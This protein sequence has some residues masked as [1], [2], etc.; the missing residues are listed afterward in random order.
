MDPMDV[1]TAPALLELPDVLLLHVLSA[2]PMRSVVAFRRLSNRARALASDNELW[3]ALM[4]REYGA[5]DGV[6][7][8]RLEG[9]AVAG[10]CIDAAREWESLCLSIG[11]DEGEHELRQR[12]APLYARAVQSWAAIGSWAEAAHPRL[13]ATLGPPASANEWRTY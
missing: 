4:R 6:P 5:A 10:A 1:C 3:Q 11:I 2:L 12:F 13:H 7:P 9:N 8:P